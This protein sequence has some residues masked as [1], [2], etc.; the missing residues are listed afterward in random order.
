[1]D[2]KPCRLACRKTRS[3]KMSK[4]RERQRQTDRAAGRLDVLVGFPAEAKQ[5]KR[6]WLSRRET[7]ET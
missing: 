1:M 6:L 7:F 2:S 5:T 4:K 3:H